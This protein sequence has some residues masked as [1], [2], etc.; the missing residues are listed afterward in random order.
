MM[1][2]NR[3]NE[4]ECLKRVSGLTGIPAYAMRPLRIIYVVISR[5]MVDGVCLTAFEDHRKGFEPTVSDDHP[6]YF[7]TDYIAV[8]R[9]T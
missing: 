1:S 5:R 6:K 3:F 8:Y 2:A 4:M 9:E 7:D